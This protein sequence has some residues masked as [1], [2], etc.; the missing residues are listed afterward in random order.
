MNVGVIEATILYTLPA[1]SI[2]TVKK[3]VLPPLLP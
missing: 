3:L 1:I 2:G